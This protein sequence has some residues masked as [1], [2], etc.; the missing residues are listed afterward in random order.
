MLTNEFYTPVSNSLDLRFT[1][2]PFLPYDALV[3]TV[4]E[5]NEFCGKFFKARFFPLEYGDEKDGNHGSYVMGYV[6]HEEDESFNQMIIGNIPSMVYWDDVFD[7]WNGFI[8]T[9]QYAG[10]SEIYKKVYG[11]YIKHEPIP[12]DSDQCA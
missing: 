10:Y 11:F 9:F 6:L 8:V 3:C 5:Y 1:N 7:R 4:P 2:S 12:D